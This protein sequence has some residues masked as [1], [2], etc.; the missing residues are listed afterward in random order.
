MLMFHGPSRMSLLQQRLAVPPSTLTSA[1]DCLEKKKLVRRIH[2][3]EDKR[4]LMVELTAEGTEIGWKL[5]KENNEIFKQKITK[6]SAEE[7]DDFWQAIETLE[8]L[9][10]KIGE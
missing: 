10:K 5:R 9:I 8:R 1:I 4:V 6:L 2:S 3:F 7:Q